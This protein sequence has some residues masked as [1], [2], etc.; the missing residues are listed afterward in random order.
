MLLPSEG[1]LVPR[2]EDDVAEA[3][4]S[5]Y[6]DRRALPAGRP[7]RR[8]GPIAATLYW[9][10]W[11]AWHVTGLAFIGSFWRRRFPGKVFAV[12]LLA[13]WLTV[14]LAVARALIPTPTEPSAPIV[15]AAPKLEITRVRS[16]VAHVGRWSVKLTGYGYTSRD[17]GGLPSHRM[18]W[19]VTKWRVTNLASRPL[20]L[21][22][23]DFSAKSLGMEE[24]PDFLAG[25]DL[26][27]RGMPHSGFALPRQ[28]VHGTEV[29]PTFRSARMI[30]VIFDPSDG[31]PNFARETWTIRR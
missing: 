2:W 15:G 16:T 14:T 10:G 17:T 12:L 30:R 19:L 5:A 31:N 26:N 23:L 9:I 8:I 20:Q 24:G 28:T 29:I 1:G 7:P 18:V 3:I 21:S 27:L 25:S 13:I 4:R 22:D 6:A 11:L